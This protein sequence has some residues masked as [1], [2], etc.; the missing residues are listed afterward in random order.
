MARIEVKFDNTLQQS[1][2]IIPLANSSRAEAQEAY[3]ENKPSVQQTHIYGIQAPLIMINK[4]VVDFSDVISFELKNEK[5]LPEVHLIVNDRYNLTTIL[6]T[7]SLDNELRIQILPKFED[8]YKKINLTFFITKMKIDNG[9]VQITGEYKLSNFTSNNFKSFGKINPYKLCQTIAQ[10]TQLG[11][12]TNVAD[13]TELERYIYCDNKSYKDL[14][15]DEISKSCTT[16]QIFEYWIDWWNNLILVDIME[17]YNA[18]D[19]DDELLIWIAG[20]NKEM[21][22][23]AEIEPTQV[24]SSFTNHPSQTSN[25]LFVKTYQICNSPGPSTKKGTDKVFSVYECGKGEYLDYLVQDGDVKKDIFKKLEYLGETY[26]DH[27]Y[28]LSSKMHES[29]KQK[30]ASNETIEIELKSPLL[31]V[32]RGNRTNF[33]WYINDSATE[34]MQDNLQEMGCTVEDPQSNIPLDENNVEDMNQN[35]SFVLDKTISGQ[36]LIT[37]CNMKYQDQQWKYVVTISRPTSAKPKLINED[38]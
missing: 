11:F 16:T 8:K 36:Y 25:E 6:D 15:R 37:K 14:L 29:F 13:N 31:G 34:N 28:L 19:P 27:N 18:I 5:I 22:E 10:E 17:R 3:T 2:I 23:G 30:M 21:E 1:N 32:M 33:L 20:Q 35:G 24:I 38:E 12:A 9:E 26:G 4:I 7:P